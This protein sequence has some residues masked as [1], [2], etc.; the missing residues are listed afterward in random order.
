MPQM[1]LN[2]C[3][4]GKKSMSAAPRKQGDPCKHVITPVTLRPEA[5]TPNTPAIGDHVKLRGQSP[6]GVLEFFDNRKLAQV[7]WDEPFAGPA[8]VHLHELEKI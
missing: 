1:Y 3:S 7:R 8:L 2:T 5:P 4:C 6:R